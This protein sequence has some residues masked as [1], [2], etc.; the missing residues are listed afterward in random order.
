MSCRMDNQSISSGFGG[1][2]Y[3]KAS[4][5]GARVV[6]DSVTVRVWAPNADGV[7]LCGD[8]N[9]W[10]AERH[11]LERSEDDGIWSIT[12]PRELF[13]IGSKYKLAVKKNG[14]TVMK[15]DPYAL[16]TEVRGN[17]ASVL[18]DISGFPWGDERWLDF[19]RRTVKRDGE[20][21]YG[22]PMNVYELHLA[23]W[24]TRDGN[25]NGD[26]SA[27][28]NYREIADMLAPYVK[29]MGYTHVE[30]LPIAEYPCEASLGYQAC[31]YFAPTSRFGSPHDLMYFV[32][33]MHS[34]GVGVILDW[35]PAHFANDEH[36]LADFDGT[37][38]YE[39]GKYT[40]WGSRAFDTSKKYV[41]EF[42]ISSA[43]FWLEKYHFDGLR[44]DAVD[45]MLFPDSSDTENAD[46][47]SFLREFNSVVAE[48]YPDVITVAEESAAYP[49][50]TRSVSECGLGFG[51][52]WNMGWAR[53]SLDYMRE[54]PI[55]RRYFHGKLTF[56]MVYAYSE[57]FILPISHDEVS[58]GKGSLAGKQFGNDADKL[59]GA[60]AYLMYMMA[61]P[62]KK[63]TF[64]GSELAQLSEWSFDRQLDWW[65]L[66]KNEHRAFQYFTAALNEF[67]LKNDTLWY[68]DFSWDGFR[69]VLPDEAERNLLA[70]ER[71]NGSGGRLLCVF[72]F[73][74]ADVTDHLIKPPRDMQ[75][76][77]NVAE[78]E[79]V[80]STE[81]GLAVGIKPGAEGEL[82]ISLPQRSAVYLAPKRGIEF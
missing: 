59:R 68:D 50:V 54:D 35:N 9:G 64:M 67:Y 80:F 8:H 57:R 3:G 19:R 77:C 43:M 45:S 7:W 61:H 28:L 21:W 5:M 79:T 63:L 11:P 30:L 34:A 74:G 33:T 76:G 20:R 22:F 12:L 66:D 29:Q 41:R 23:S 14:R 6:G 75:S 46:S 25:P 65:L 38:L 10:N 71:R 62:G 73:S 48:R 24:R 47:V 78:W 44:V 17:G 69:W 82:R 4:V 39:S 52:K 60:R 56:S 18:A 81:G 15:G 51:M 13:P 27:C 53:D 72:N 70:F 37:P 58:G 2:Q 31:S 16:A 36:G 55:F 49:G 40:Q 26:G 32:N 42:L 1:E